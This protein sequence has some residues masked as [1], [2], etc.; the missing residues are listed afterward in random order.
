MVKKLR[1]AVLM[2]G[3]SSEREVSLQ[4]GQAVLANLDPAKYEAIAVELHG[5]TADPDSLP[6]ELRN[7][8]IDLAFLVLHGGAGEDGRLQQALAQVGLR[9]TGSGPRASAQALDKIVAR[10]IFQQAGLR[11]PRGQGFRCLSPAQLGAAGAE[12]RSSLGLPL[13]VKPACEGSTIGI[14]IVREEK[15]LLPAFELARRYGADLL[16]EQ[17]IAGRELTAAVI[18]NASPRVLPLIEIVPRSG[19]YDYHAKYIASDTDKI[20]PAPLPEK[21][22]EE[23]RRMA[24]A[25][26]Q[27]LGCRGFARVDFIVTES[28]VYLLEVNTIPGMIGDHSLVPCAARAAGMPLPALLDEIVQLALEEGSHEA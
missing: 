18:G 28:E 16:V 5:L 7:G 9:Y 21:L 20:V 15:E 24:A 10:R 22:A 26:Y 12:A 25:A 8:H 11:V 19:F 23:V 2:G 6:A 17:F 1:V 4:S 14:T 3:D 13:V 27:A